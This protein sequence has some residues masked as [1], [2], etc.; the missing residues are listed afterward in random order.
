MHLHITFQQNSKVLSKEKASVQLFIFLHKFQVKVVSGIKAFG[1]SL[2]TRIQ[3][4]VNSETDISI[5]SDPHGSHVKQA[6]VL[7][8]YI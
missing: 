7:F 1:D 6:F 4:G 5:I 8:H 3:F 2:E